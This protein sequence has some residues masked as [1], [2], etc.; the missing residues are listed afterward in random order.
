M[1]QITLATVIYDECVNQLKRLEFNTRELRTE[2][3]VVVDNKRT[4]S[5]VKNF[6]KKHAR[7]LVRDLK[8]ETPQMSYNA[9]LEEIKTEWFL[10][11]DPDEFLVEEIVEYIKKIP[12][13]TDKNGFVMARENIIYWEGKK[14][15]GHWKWP[16]PQ[17]RLFR[18][19][20]RYPGIIHINAQVPMPIEAIKEGGIVH[21]WLT[22]ID[23]EYK[24]KIKNYEAW[25]KVSKVVWK[26]KKE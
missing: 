15:Q 18:S 14:L 4:S 20:Y 13:G 25:E 11:V 10:L 26:V 3:I 8:K 19:K 7:I 23:E 16:D 17:L 24:R 9:I 5:E 1:I 6:V 2:W 12:E 21:D 22:R